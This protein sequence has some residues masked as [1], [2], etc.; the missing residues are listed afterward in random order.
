[1]FQNIVAALAD[2]LKETVLSQHLQRIFR[3]FITDLNAVA[4]QHFECH[5]RGTSRPHIF[6]SVTSTI[7]P[8]ATTPQSKNKTSTKIGIATANNTTTKAQPQ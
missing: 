2:A 8:S 4:R 3:E 7:N 6:H 1:M 5:V